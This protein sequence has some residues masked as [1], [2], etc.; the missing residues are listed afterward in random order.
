RS[1]SRCG[2]DQHQAHPLLQALCGPLA[3]PLRDTVAPRLGGR[4]ARSGSGR[5][6]DLLALRIRELEPLLPDVPTLVR[7]ARLEVAHAPTA[8][9]TTTSA[10]PS[11]R[12]CLTS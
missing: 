10:R 2:A 11:A 4:T 1:R 9:E 5:E 3:A 12:R 6:R 7:R 8:R